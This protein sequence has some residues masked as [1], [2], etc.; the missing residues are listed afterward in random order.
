MKMKEALCA[1]RKTLKMV[2]WRAQ[3]H[4]EKNEKHIWILGN[5]KR[6]VLLGHLLSKQWRVTHRNPKWKQAWNSL[7]LINKTVVS[8]QC[9]TQALLAVTCRSLGIFFLPYL[10][11]VE[12]D[13]CLVRACL[14]SSWN[15]DTTTF[16][17]SFHFRSDQCFYAQ[18][19]HSHLYV[20]AVKQA[21]R[22]I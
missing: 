14:W 7:L 19:C 18:W 16:S 13:D 9:Y 5:K 12:L 2:S 21:W 6:K 22:Q 3:Q 8:W 11:I 10:L 15:V 1:Q 17:L 20:A 4:F